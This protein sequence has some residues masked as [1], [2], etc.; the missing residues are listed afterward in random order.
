MPSSNPYARS[1]ARQTLP[2]TA[3]ALAAMAARQP[4][5]SIPRLD[6]AAPPQLQP[7]W[8]GITVPG[9]TTECPPERADS[10]RAASGWARCSWDPRS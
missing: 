7:A 10:M 9:L 4:L 5:V 8:G 3:L 1:K 6:A 2:P